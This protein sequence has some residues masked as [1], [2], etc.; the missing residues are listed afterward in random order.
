MEM[1]FDVGVD[2]SVE[3]LHHDEFPLQFL[4]KAKVVRASEIIFN[5][6]SQLWDVI[7]PGAS[8][9]ACESCAGFPSYN[10]ARQFEVSWLN[11]CRVS[12]VRPASDMG[13]INAALERSVLD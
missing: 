8:Q 12:A 10:T 11:A 6:D 9:P 5:E 7:L 13:R 3:G 2:G 1:V 4:G